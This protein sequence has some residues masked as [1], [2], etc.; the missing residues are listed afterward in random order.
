MS[1]IQNTTNY[2]KL[3]PSEAVK[4][5]ISLVEIAHSRNTYSIPETYLAFNAIHT[6]T[7]DKSYDNVHNYINKHITQ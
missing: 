5:L 2:D 3:T 1:D 4:V 7:S 6:F